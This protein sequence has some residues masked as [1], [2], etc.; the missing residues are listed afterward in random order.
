MVDL[1][2]ASR[3]NKAH[4]KALTKRTKFGYIMKAKQNK[5][6]GAHPDVVQYVQA[7]F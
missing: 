4:H 2:V 3:I 1:E 6:A 5:E 7:E